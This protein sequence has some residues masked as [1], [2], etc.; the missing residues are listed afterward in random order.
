MPQANT[1]SPSLFAVLVEQAAQGH[2]STAS[3]V[4]N[5]QANIP[6][7]FRH[8]SASFSKDAPGR[9]TVTLYRDAQEVG[10]KQA[11]SPVEAK[12]LVLDYLIAQAREDLKANA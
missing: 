3:L 7:G 9:Y 11:S 4:A 12:L 5:V 10:N 6:F 1:L 2:V 8:V